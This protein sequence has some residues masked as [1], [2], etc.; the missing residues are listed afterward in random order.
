MVYFSRLIAL[1]TLSQIVLAAKFN[2]IA[3][4]GKNVQVSVNG[5]NVP[6]KAPDADVPYFTG[7]VS[8]Y[9]GATYKYIVDNVEEK[10]IRHLKGDTTK[11]DFYNRRIT[12]ADIP[13]L[14]TVIG[15]N[16]W[17]QAIAPGAIWD[18]NYIPS[19]FVTIDEADEEQLVEGLSKDIYKAKITIIDAHEVH[20]FKDSNFQ[21]HK[22]GKKHNNNKQSWKWELP[23]GQVLNGRTFFKIRHMEEDPTQIR[24]KL[25]AD[26]LRAMGTNANQANMIRFFIN[27]EFFGTFN[28]LDDIPNYSYVRANFYKGELPKQVGP[29]FDGAS[30][31]SFEDDQVTM[32]AFTPAP[33]SSNNKE[34]LDNLLAELDIM[35]PKNDQDIENFANQFNLDQFLRF[36][37]MEYLAGHWDGYWQEQTNIGLYEDIANN[38][39]YFLAQDFDATFGVNLDNT[40]GKDFV[41]VSYKKYPELFP[42]GFL[43]NKVLENNKVRSTF[44]SYIQQTVTKVF[45]NHTLTNHILAYHDFILPDLK[46]DRSIEQKS[47]GI[48][49]GWEFEQ[50]T[51]NLWHKVKSP[52]DE[53]VGGANWG[54][55]EWIVAKSQAVAKEFD[56]KLYGNNDE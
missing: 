7:D 36:M 33:G 53:K 14:P 49:Y 52:V 37:V 12:Y 21:L 15:K 25:Y 13:K 11:N 18:T 20:T 3:P 5:Q 34:L 24:E 17:N 46:W 22:P 9:R 2:V 35:D 55:I 43:I 6:L 44:E 4:G 38:K 19:V 27:G 50:V 56:L 8:A 10:F 40:L 41:S 23:E 28:M 51:E 31:A 42:K 54:L 32:D 45:N 29:L 1:T 30:G 26:I 16:D 48:N 39:V 47:K